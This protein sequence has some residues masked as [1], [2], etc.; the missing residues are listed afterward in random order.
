MAPQ[1][2]LCGEGRGQLER[3]RHAQGQALPRQL[4][5]LGGVSS[6]PQACFFVYMMMI[7]SGYCLAVGTTELQVPD[8][9]RGVRDPAK[10]EASMLA[11][12]L[13]SGPGL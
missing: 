9:N 2:C 11:G 10:C 6:P 1:V 3:Q 7:W 13:R 12:S 4:Y 5:G 8:P